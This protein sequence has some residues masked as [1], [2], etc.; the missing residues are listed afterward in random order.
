LFLIDISLKKEGKKRLLAKIAYG[1]PSAQPG[2]ATPAI[3]ILIPYA[4]ANKIANAII[5][6]LFIINLI[7]LFI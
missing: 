2:I 6:F 4:T 1:I 5:L 3:D 7:K